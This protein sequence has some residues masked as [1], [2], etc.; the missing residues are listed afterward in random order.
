MLH[1][2]A[3]GSLSVIVTSRCRHH[4]PIGREAGQHTAN[5]LRKGRIGVDREAWVSVNQLVTNRRAACE[6]RGITVAT[7]VQRSVNAIMALQ[8]APRH[9]RRHTRSD[10]TLST[11]RFDSE[12]RSCTHLHFAAPARNHSWWVP[13]IHPAEIR[14]RMYRARRSLYSHKSEWLTHATFQE[15]ST[16]SSS[17]KKLFREP[18]ISPSHGSC[19]NDCQTSM[20]SLIMHRS[21]KA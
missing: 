15:E 18:S 1:S 4:R 11:W 3:L 21:Q 8:Q 14:K 16:S 12:F 13:F 10:A 20:R 19:M 5:M 9:A 17:M 2:T 7:D 6:T